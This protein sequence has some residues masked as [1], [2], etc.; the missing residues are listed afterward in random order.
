MPSRSRRCL[1]SL[2][3]PALPVAGCGGEAAASPRS[4][5]SGPAVELDA[6]TEARLQ[7]AFEHA[8]A[9]TFADGIPNGDTIT[10]RQLLST[11]AGV[12]SDT[13]GTDLIARFQAHPMTPWTI[14]QTIELIRTQPADHPLGTKHVSSDSNDVLLGRT[15]ELVTGRGV[16]EVIRTAVIE[17]LGLTSTRMPADDQPGVPGPSLDSS[18]PVDGRLVAVP[19]LNPD[20][21]WAAGAVTS[22][23]PGP[24][25]C[26]EELTAG[27]L[28]GQLSPEQLPSR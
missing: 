21:A 16:S 5:A 3:L 6:A 10:I 7:A 22:T 18:M 28:I 23:A 24:A 14:D 17:P 12:R 4:T 2:V 26:A 13:A 20:V 1:V 15:L 11:S 9:T 27:A 25:R 8:F 19:E